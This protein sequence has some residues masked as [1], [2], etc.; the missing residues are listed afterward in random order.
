MMK[1]IKKTD[2]KKVVKKAEIESAKN[3]LSDF[4]EHITKPI[5]KPKSKR[6]KPK[7]K[8]IDDKKTTG[9][10]G[11]RKTPGSKPG[12]TNDKGD[13]GQRP[14]G[15]KTKV[16]GAIVKGGERSGFERI[17]GKILPPWF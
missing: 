9:K 14:G 12:R 15:D 7:E 2:L 17:L 3:R 1:K 4:K 10:K 8:T 13:E 6:K 11:Q 16:S 5:A